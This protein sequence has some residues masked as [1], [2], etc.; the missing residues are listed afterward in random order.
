MSDTFDLIERLFASAVVLRD[1]AKRCDAASMPQSA[2]RLRMVADVCD[3]DGGELARE[4]NAARD[5]DLAQDAEHA[6]RVA[7]REEMR[8]Q[9]A[10]ELRF[11]EVE[12]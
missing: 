9:E 10:E 6:A 1:V 2:E 8:A 3:M 7:R 11:H 12:P 4:C 5:S